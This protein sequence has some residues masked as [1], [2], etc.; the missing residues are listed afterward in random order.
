VSERANTRVLPGLLLGAD[1][2]RSAF[3]FCRP[4][5]ARRDHR[6][7]PGVV[8]RAA[9]G[10]CTNLVT[11]SNGLMKS[12][13]VL[14]M[15]GLAP[16]IFDAARQIDKIRSVVTWPRAPCSRPASSNPKF[17]RLPMGSIRR[18]TVA[19]EPVVVDVGGK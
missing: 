2:L 3:P 18:K 8:A 16:A 10:R 1:H 9:R 4:P 14:A 17:P 7:E 15:H 5:V 11:K 19:A 6:P 13:G 12:I